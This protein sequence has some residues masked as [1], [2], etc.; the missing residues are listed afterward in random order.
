MEHMKGLYCCRHSINTD[1][2]GQA[3]TLEGLQQSIQ[4]DTQGG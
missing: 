3:H 2:A 1:V 4:D